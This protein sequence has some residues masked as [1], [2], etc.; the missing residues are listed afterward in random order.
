MYSN[1]L[2]VFNLNFLPFQL[3]ASFDSLKRQ[4]A[5][6]KKNIEDRK[7]RLDD[8]MNLFNQRKAQYQSQQATLGKKKK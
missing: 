2:N 5:D 3:H 8:E 7:K 6:Q 4:H 1:V